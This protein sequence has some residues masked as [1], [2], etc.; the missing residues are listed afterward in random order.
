MTDKELTEISKFLSY[1]L[2]HHPEAIDLVLDEHGWA[3]ID[4]LIQKAGREGKSLS[5]EKL[6]QVIDSGS[7]NRFTISEDGA[8]IRAGYGHSIE[9]DLSLVPVAP[10]DILYHGTARKN[11]E[12]IK[13]NGLH[14][15]SRNYVHLSKHERDAKT[16]GHRHGQP[17]VLSIEAGTMHRSGYPF[18]QSESKSD[19]WLVDRVPPKFISH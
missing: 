18:Y 3:P 1:I 15:G 19:I 8:Y 4:T 17:V 2:R 13:E 5:P 9:V 7:K 6:Q 16:V 10:P 11:M 12:S 14:S